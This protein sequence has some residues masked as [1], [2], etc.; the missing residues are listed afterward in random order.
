L[1]HFDSSDIGSFSSTVLLATDERQNEDDKAMV[2]QKDAFSAQLTDFAPAE[3][4]DKKTVCQQAE[5]LKK[6]DMLDS[7]LN[8]VS[9]PILIL[10]QQR[11]IVY[12][13]KAFTDLVGQRHDE[14]VGLRP[15]EAINCIHAFT[16]PGGCGTT[17][18][19]SMCGAARGILAAQCGRRDVQECR[20]LTGSAKETGAFDLR[21]TTTPFN[22]NA[23]DNASFTMFAAVDISGEK[24]RQALEH[25]FFHDIANTAGAISGLT[26]LMLV[27]KSIDPDQAEELVSMLH[28]T[29]DRLID[30]IMAQRQL[31]AAEQG[32]LAVRPEMVYSVDFLQRMMDVYGNHHIGEGKFLRLDSGSAQVAFWSDEAILGRVIGNM[33]KNALEASK[34]GDTVTA[35]CEQ[36][37]QSVR[38][39]VHNPKPM[40][41][42]VQLQLFQR[43]FSTKGSNRGL[44]TY[45]MKLLTET[46]LNGQISFKSNEAEGTTF[47]ATYPL[48]WADETV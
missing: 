47:M 32:E 35:G 46:Y 10:N 31:L 39:W 15:G 8:A 11:Q 2:N 26:E 22:F 27:S 7:L 6:S 18:H 48:E 42:E 24:R 16:K 34:T 40:P 1:Y 19:C 25:I 36:R 33:M 38:F 41:R 17:E 29:S 13:N 9:D 14:V 12:A 28:Q 20:I 4:A 44:G 5:K 23:E 30:E 37:E 43:S 21:V 3:R 45:S